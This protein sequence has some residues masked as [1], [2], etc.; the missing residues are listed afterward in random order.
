[1]GQPGPIISQINVLFIMSDEPQW[2]SNE[3]FVWLPHLWLITLGPAN[4]TQQANGVMRSDWKASLSSCTCS[5]RLHV[6]IDWMTSWTISCLQAHA[7][8]TCLIQYLSEFRQGSQTEDWLFLICC[9]EI[10][11]DLMWWRV[12]GCFCVVF[13]FVLLAKNTEDVEALNTS[14][15]LY[16]ESI[17]TSLLSFV[18]LCWVNFRT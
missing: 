7:C 18:I 2:S 8:A 14:M 17:H 4:Q 11:P 1:M 13:F 15:V 12:F 10:V 6:F 3:P 16:S 5:L 9:D